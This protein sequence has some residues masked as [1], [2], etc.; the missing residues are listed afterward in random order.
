LSVTF[1]SE[2]KTVILTGLV[3]VVDNVQANTLGSGQANSL[4]CFFMPLPV[5]LEA[6]TAQEQF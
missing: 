6:I 3:K 4:S 5:R 2:N 1:Q